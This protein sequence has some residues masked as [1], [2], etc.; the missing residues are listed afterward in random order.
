MK[1]FLMLGLFFSATGHAQED[2]ADIG[3]LNG[4]EFN[5]Q[6]SPAGAFTWFQGIPIEFTSHSGAD[7]AY[8]A[9]NFEST[10]ANGTICNYLIVPDVPMSQLNFWTRSRTAMDGK[11]VYPDRLRVMYSSSGNKVPGDCTNDF[12][13]FSEE[14]LVINPNL[15]TTGYPLD[16]WTEYNVNIPGN[17]RVAFVYHVDDAGS[18]G[19]NSNYIGIDTV[20]L[21]EDL[22]FSDGFEQA[23]P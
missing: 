19:T 6:S 3:N 10:G 7:D 18:N 9:A 8:I 4:W 5:N 22:I 21:I 1:L 16:S 13:D 15:T 17:G 23:A 2:F 11:V 14:L 12:G 20:S